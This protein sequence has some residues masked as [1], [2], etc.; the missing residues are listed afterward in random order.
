[1]KSI[2]TSIA[3]GWLSL[4]PSDKYTEQM[5]KNIEV[6]YSSQ[7]ADELQQAVNAF[8]RIGNAEK[9]KWQPFYYASFGYLMIANAQQDAVKKDGYLDLALAQNEKAR[10]ASPDNSEVTAMLGFIHMI[11]VTVDP[12]SRGQQYSMLAMQSFGKAIAIDPSNPRALALMAQM[13]FGTAQFFQQQPT[14]ACATAKKALDLFNTTPASQDPI[15]PSWG[16]GM[17]EKLA[18]QC[19]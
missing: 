16:K 11:R 13:Q 10:L 14:E 18:A 19:N 9:D 15:A 8:E 2:I 1:M 12:A 5:T 6:V 17:T 4:A 7:S 3:L